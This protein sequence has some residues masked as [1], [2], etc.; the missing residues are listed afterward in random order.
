MRPICSKLLFTVVN[1]IFLTCFM[2][3]MSWLVGVQS[4]PCS[5]NFI[6]II[7]LL[8]YFIP[9]G[10]IGFQTVIQS[11]SLK[12]WLKSLGHGHN[13]GQKSPWMLAYPCY[14]SVQSPMDACMPISRESSRV[15]WF[16]ISVGTRDQ[17]PERL[18]QFLRVLLLTWKVYMVCFHGFN[19]LEVTQDVES[20]HSNFSSY[21]YPVGWLLGQIWE[22]GV[23]KWYQSMVHLQ[24]QTG[25]VCF[26]CIHVVCMCFNH[27]CGLYAYF[28]TMVLVMVVVMSPC[29]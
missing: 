12:K 9:E 8:L 18:G 29:E 5:R 7:F 2:K 14:G 25:S 26:S 16:N 17:L 28:I 3:F 4:S 20:Y 13:T 10:A 27:S 21:V 6:C 22:E 15:K 19:F 23:T 24:D 1:Y 11:G